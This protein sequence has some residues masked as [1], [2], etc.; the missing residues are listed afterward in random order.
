LK[1]QD[2]KFH[3]YEFKLIR[4]A[5]N[6]IE[7]IK[8]I[9]KYF[10]S[11]YVPKKLFRAT[12]VV[13]MDLAENIS[14]QADLFNEVLTAEKISKI[15]GSVDGISE[16]YG[17]HTLFLGSSFKAM[18]TAQHQGSR[19]IMAERKGE[20]FKGETAR[21]RIAIPFLGEAM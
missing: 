18:N 13:M 4:P 15:F 1:T 20:L 12:G 2:F 9:N 16:R 3:G 8:M 7:M 19:Q 5:D 17:K 14:R 10:D 11:V 21:K 6:P